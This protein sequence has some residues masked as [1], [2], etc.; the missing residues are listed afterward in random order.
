MCEKVRGKSMPNTEEEQE[1]F[2]STEKHRE[3]NDENRKNRTCETN[4][5]FNIVAGRHRRRHHTIDSA[6]YSKFPFVCVWEWVSALQET[7]LNSLYSVK[8]YV[9]I[10]AF[11]P[12]FIRIY[13]VWCLSRALSSSV[14]L[15]IF[16]F[17]SFYLILIHFLS[18]YSTCSFSPVYTNT[19]RTVRR[20]W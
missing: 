8:L 1:S 2:S 11:P 7:Y 17:C 14:S 18:N 4:D 5:G 9:W 12:F 16:I 19:V 13:T 3:R 15:F 6:I 10:D 20:R